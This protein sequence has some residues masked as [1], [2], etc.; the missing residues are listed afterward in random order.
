M[1][2]SGWLSCSHFSL[3]CFWPGIL[4][5]ATASESLLLVRLQEFFCPASSDL[6]PQKLCIYC[7]SGVF[8]FCLYL[9]L[10]PRPVVRKLPGWG[11]VA[12]NPF[13]LIFWSQVCCCSVTHLE[14]NQVSNNRHTTSC[15]TTMPFYD[16]MTNYY[17]DYLT[18]L[19]S[20]E[21]RRFSLSLFIKVALTTWSLASTALL[22]YILVRNLSLYLFVYFWQFYIIFTWIINN[23]QFPYIYINNEE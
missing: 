23:D 16:T 18:S 8:R 1:W 10:F 14:R 13:I 7:P 15:C 22:C 17:A 21:E 12:I 19:Y 2:A 6:S 9:R 5:K 20:T 3:F 11:R 4:L